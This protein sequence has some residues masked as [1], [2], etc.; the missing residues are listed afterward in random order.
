[1]RHL[2]ILEHGSFLGVS[3]SRL[4]IKSEGKTVKEIPL[5]RI[6]SIL[7]AKSGV[8]FSGKLVT[9]CAVRGIR[10]FFMDQR[11]KIIA[12]LADMKQ[13]AVSA[14]RKAQFFRCNN[15]GGLDAGRNIALAKIK[16]QRALLLYFSKGSDSLPRDILRDSAEQMD[17]DI[18]S[19]QAMTKDEFS[20]DTIMGYEG[21]AGRKYWK[22]LRESELLP[23]SFKCRSGRGATEPV[24]AALNYG[25]AI[26]MSFVWNAVLNAGMESYEGVLHVGR[27]G[28]PSLVLDMM[29]EFRP[30]VVDRHIIRLRSRLATN[31][32]QL[33]FPLRKTIIE[34]IEDCMVTKYPWRNR[35]LR[36]DTI[37]QRQAWR[38]S[39]YF[40]DDKPY[41]GYLFKW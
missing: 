14:V 35:R 18:K 15:Y 13:H 30:W 19:L 3:G 32:G 37:I 12:H 34:R 28:K 7:V 39:A 41:K 11:G 36:M 16:N 8:G 23:E 9:E 17:R 4:Q 1:M 29:E 33:S 10:T 24:N 38:M 6:K 26:L 22:A 27:P 2:S 21:V 20:I 5:S 31:K 40:C 25:Y